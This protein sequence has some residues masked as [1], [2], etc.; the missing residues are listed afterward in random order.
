MTAIEVSRLPKHL[1]QAATVADLMNSE[2]GRRWWL[3]NGTARFMEFDLTP[4]SRSWQTL[5][6][7]LQEKGVKP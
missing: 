6:T 4:G 3:A 7:I 1:S 2:S 5:R